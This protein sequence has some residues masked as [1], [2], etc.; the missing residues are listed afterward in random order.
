MNIPLSAFVPENLVSRD[1]FGSPVPHQP[2]H[3]H[4]QAES[5]G[6]SLFDESFPNEDATSASRSLHEGSTKPP[7]GW[8]KPWRRLREGFSVSSR[9]LQRPR[10]LHEGFNRASRL[11]RE[12]FA[13]HPRRLSGESPSRR[14][15]DVF[16]TSSR[17][18]HYGGFMNPSFEAF[19][20]PSDGFHDKP[21]TPSNREGQYAP[22][23][24]W[25]VGE[26]RM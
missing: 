22:P 11:L 12:V 17:R 5:R 9:S 23:E 24:A 4:T 7:W 13:E 18:D 21:G 8:V 15:R 16:A 10:R 1:G 20:D 19:V 2:A 14:H 6:L 25:I 3:L 26:P